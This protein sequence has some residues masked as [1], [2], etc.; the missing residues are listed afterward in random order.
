MLL[1]LAAWDG[2]ASGAPLTSSMSKGVMFMAIAP[3]LLSGALVKALRFVRFGVNP[4]P[5]YRR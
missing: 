5:I 3:L 1:G 2:A 4:P